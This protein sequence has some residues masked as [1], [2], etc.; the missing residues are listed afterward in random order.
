MIGSM[1]IIG[2]RHNG[3]GGLQQLKRIKGCSALPLPENQNE[4]GKK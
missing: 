3:L 2:G 1:G 4:Y